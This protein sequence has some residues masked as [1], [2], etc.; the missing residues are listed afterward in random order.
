MLS[1]KSKDLLLRYIRSMSTVSNIHSGSYDY[2]DNDIYRWFLKINMHSNII[3]IP[4]FLRYTMEKYIYGNLDYFRDNGSFND[5]VFAISSP[6]GMYKARTANSLLDYLITTFNEREPIKVITKK[7]EEYYGYKGVFFDKN[8]RILYMNVFEAKLERYI[9]TYNRLVTY[10][11]PSVFTSDGTLEKEI[12]R[13]IIPLLV[14]EV[15]R[16][17]NS[18]YTNVIVPDSLESIVKIEDATNKF[19]CTP[20]SPH[21]SRFDLLNMEIKNLLLLNI[22]EISESMN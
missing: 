20:N 9:L 12:V 16:M 3:E 2:Y 7:N 6:S 22:D 4:A 14:T 11:H 5:I 15:N 1:Q 13:R 17:I 21:T 18:N 8:M 10:V 19:I